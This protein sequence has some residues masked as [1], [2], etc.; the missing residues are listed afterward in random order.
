M[1]FMLSMLT[2]YFKVL[3]EFRNIFPLSLL[4]HCLLL[5]KVLANSITNLISTAN[6]YIFNLDFL[7]AKI[8]IETIY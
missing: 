8:A 6:S 4:L 3:L 7:V 2:V 5:V 1:N